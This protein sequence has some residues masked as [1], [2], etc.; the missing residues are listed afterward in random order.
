MFQVSN[1]CFSYT[2]T[3]SQIV[4]ITLVKT[5]W[6]FKLHTFGSILILTI[7]RISFQSAQLKFFSIRVNVGLAKWLNETILS[8]N[9]Q[10]N[11]LCY[12]RNRSETSL[13]LGKVSYHMT[14]FMIGNSH[15][16]K[17]KRFD[18]IVQCLMV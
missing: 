13:Y 16:I 11:A 12:F 17:Q 9:P 14:S 5:R 6:T 1:E 15:Y 8:W 3:C 4:A 7:I 2:E 10:S 18:I